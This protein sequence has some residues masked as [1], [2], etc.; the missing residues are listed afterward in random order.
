MNFRLDV[1]IRTFLALLAVLVFPG[2]GDRSGNEPT[3]GPARNTAKPTGPMIAGIGLQEDQF[4]RLIE[5]GMRDAAKNHGIDLA[6]ANSSGTLDKEISLVDTFAAQ[7]VKAIVVAPQSVKASIPAL[8]RAH[9]A[10]IK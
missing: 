5:L 1:R 6:V 9:D 7:K 10:G 3:T 8:Q 2:C 4:Y